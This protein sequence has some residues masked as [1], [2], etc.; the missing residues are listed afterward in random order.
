[1]A[2]GFRNSSSSIS[3]GG[4]AGPSQFGSLVIVFDANFVGMSLLPSERDAILVVDPNAV[5]PCLIAL[6][7][8]ESITGRNREIF[9][10]RRD[11]ERLELPLRD[12]PDLARDPPRQN[13]YCVRETG[14][15]SFRCRKTESTLKLRYTDSV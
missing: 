7:R 10:S 14:Q 11:V 8:L 2:I 4:I 5:P 3:P 6:Q 1:M 13:A 15:P 12:S 9:E